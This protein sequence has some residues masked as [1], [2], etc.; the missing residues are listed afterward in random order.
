MIGLGTVQVVLLKDGKVLGVS[1][2]FDHNDFGLIGG[3]INDDDATIEDAAKREAMEE[4][5]LTVFNLK[6]IYR[7]AES[8]GRMGYTF[9]ADYSGEINYSEPHVVK[10]TTFEELK[11]GSFGEWNSDVQIAL[12]RLGL[13]IK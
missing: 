5:G 13:H 2:K 6:L 4:T 7:N 8:N 12:R 11:R 3:S 9:L 10:W 1:R